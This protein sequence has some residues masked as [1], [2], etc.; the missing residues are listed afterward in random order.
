LRRVAQISRTR[1][2]RAP[3]IDVQRTLKMM[4]MVSVQRYN[5]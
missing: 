2:A 5:S 1:A 4:Y 3:E